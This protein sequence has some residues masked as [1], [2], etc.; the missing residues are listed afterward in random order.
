MEASIRFPINL[1]KYNLIEKT[2]TRSED[3]SDFT[4][5]QIDSLIDW[6]KA[7]QISSTN[8]VYTQVPFYQNNSKL[9]AYISDKNLIAT[10]SL[11]PYKN[12]YVKKENISGSIEKEY[13]VMMIPTYYS[14]KYFPEYS[15]LRKP[16]FTGVAIFS[17]IYG[18]YSHTEMYYL[19]EVLDGELLSEDSDEY[20][21]K[22]YVSFYTA[23]E[24]STRNGEDP[25]IH[26][27]MLE[28]VVVSASRV[29]P[30]HS[31]YFDLTRYY[32]FDLLEHLNYVEDSYFL[33][34][35]TGG[36]SD[37]NESSDDDLITHNL[38]LS[39]HY[40]GLTQLQRSQRYITGS[41]VTINAEE[42]IVDDN[43]KSY[44]FSAWSEMIDGLFSFSPNFHFRIYDDKDLTAFYYPEN[45]PCLELGE[46]LRDSSLFKTIALLQQ[47][48]K[49][50]KEYIFLID[51]KNETHEYEGDRNS[52][53][54]PNEAFTRIYKTA[55]HN[56][57]GQ[58]ILFSYS[59]L[60]TLHRFLSSDCIEDI[61]KFRFSIYTVNT[62]ITARIFNP[63]KFSE[64][65]EYYDNN[66][67]IYLEDIKAIHKIND[68]NER[69]R[70]NAE[71]LYNFGI[72]QEV[73]AITTYD[74]RITWNLYQRD[75]S[76]PNNNALK[77]K[78]CYN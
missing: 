6:E 15:F 75:M 44:L 67:L 37:N 46:M 56:H 69:C 25:I 49:E 12:F 53:S 76:K 28:G 5:V 26:D 27:G 7:D 43:N 18:E 19:G 68:Y 10:D 71:F 39:Y 13:I 31:I 70:A 72:A 42:S 29:E 40:N 62:I 34:D 1:N 38:H 50:Y 59:D 11:V 61:N 17:D 9:L 48:I 45:D 33:Y 32:N 63:E 35:A 74:N 78:Y 16:N 36:G 66:E 58:S 51:N 57:P 21:S 30:N 41:I 64:M 3:S 20:L 77:I 54:I 65:L 73:G 23:D 22:M 4:P 2:L 52:I 14:N 24:S 47:T 60:K 55:T 8:I